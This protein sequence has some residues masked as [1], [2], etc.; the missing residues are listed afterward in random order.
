ME[1][2]KGFWWGSGLALGGGGNKT[3]VSRVSGVG[4]FCRTARKCHVSARIFEKRKINSALLHVY[5]R[6]GK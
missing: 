2:L 5:F 4:V 3:G 1:V 6:N